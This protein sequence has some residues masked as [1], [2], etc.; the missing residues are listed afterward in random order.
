MN[1]P[2]VNK[3]LQ[4]KIE[5]SSGQPAHIQVRQRILDILSSSDI[6]IGDAIP[7]E[8][9]IADSLGVSR[10]TVN[11]AILGLVAEG[12]LIRQK[13]RG[14]FLAEKFREDPGRCIVLAKKAASIGLQD[15]Y[16]YG[17]LYWGIRDYFGMRD[18]RIDVGAMDEQILSKISDPGKTFLVALNPDKSEAQ[19]LKK[20]AQ[21]N[22]PVVVLGSSWEGGSIDTVDSDN[23]L[24]AALATNHLLDL[25]HRRIAF[26]G[27][28]IKDSNTVDRMEGFQF[29]M[30]ARG[31][32]VSDNDIIMGSEAGSLD[33]SDQNRLAA[34]LQGPNPIT[35][36]IAAGPSLA[37][38][39]LGLAAKC[40]VSVPNSLSIVAY[41]DPKFIS[42]THPPLT[43]VKQPLEAM[44]AT[45]CEIVTGHYP[46]T[47]SEYIHVIH[48]PVLVVR[49]STAP[50]PTSVHTR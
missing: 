26:V 41:D 5:K 18:V 10:M 49:E 3:I 39:V 9:D 4:N 15:D 21:N 36:I 48:D 2:T 34:M 30:K 29:S 35:A 32:A 14:T 17:S 47:E 13:G 43:T 12:W 38:S 6:S 44:A 45:A 22:H 20:L 23:R 40:G 8:V 46:R 16:Y 37:M 27:A 31:L 1:R 42:M 25:G 28:W 19:I 24:G 33:E 50:V 7:S 11:K